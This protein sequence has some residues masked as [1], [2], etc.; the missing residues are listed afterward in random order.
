[1]KENKRTR[2][3]VGLDKESVDGKLAMLQREEEAECLGH[4][5]EI[6]KMV[7]RGLRKKP[8]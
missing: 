1:M 4:R 3:L 5:A 6:S 2:L 7:A 8:Q